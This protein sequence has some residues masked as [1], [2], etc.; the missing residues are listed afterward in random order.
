MQ[1]P[2]VSKGFGCIDLKITGILL[3]I[4][5]IVGETYDITT[6]SPTSALSWINVP[7][8]ILWLFGIY[9]ECPKLMA[10]NILFDTITTIVF[11]IA[12]V[13]TLSAYQQSADL[14]Y[15]QM[16]ADQQF[17]VL[18][19]AERLFILLSIY[20]CIVEYSLYK[21]FVDKKNSKQNQ[22]ISNV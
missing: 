14:N 15:S 3:G 7:A 9:Y 22:P 12:P 10:P 13:F 6:A 21:S 20:L 2:T 8:T 11:F 19:A 5:S 16:T 1:I 4:L 18:I 17:I